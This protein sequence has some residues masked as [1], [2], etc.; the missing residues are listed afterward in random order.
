MMVDD[1]LCRSE[2]CAVAMCDPSAGVV[3]IKVVFEPS[4]IVWNKNS[5]DLWGVFEKS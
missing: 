2:F 4:P 1:W 3:G 5:L